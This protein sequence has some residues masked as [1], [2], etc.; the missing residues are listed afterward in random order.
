MSLLQ[1]QY[2]F[3]NL[4]EK[5]ISELILQQRQLILR[6]HS[7]NNYYLFLI[8]FFLKNI[9]IIEIEFKEDTKWGSKQS[10]VLVKKWYLLDPILI[11]LRWHWKPL[12]SGLPNKELLTSHLVVSSHIVCH[13]EHD[14][15]LLSNKTYYY[16]MWSLFKINTILNW[17][18]YSRLF[19]SIVIWINH[20]EDVLEISKLNFIQ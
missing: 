19:I 8:D 16:L 18:K 2:F 20:I 12:S 10:F 1:L 14:F 11:M 6:F 15:Y 13:Q 7:I 9:L 3:S 4:N 17:S 5:I